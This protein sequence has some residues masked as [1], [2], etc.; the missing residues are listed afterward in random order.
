MSVSEQQAQEAQARYTVLIIK[1]WTV[2]LTE[3]D[4]RELLVL[5]RILDEAD[6]PFYGPIIER[7]KGERA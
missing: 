4:A 1:K 3:D 7:V 5:D 6:E 2:G